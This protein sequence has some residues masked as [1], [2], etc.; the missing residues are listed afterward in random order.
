MSQE[1]TEIVRRLYEVWNRSGGVPALELIDPE[2]EVEAVDDTD[3][4]GAYRGHAGF[5]KLLEA[6]W[7]NFEDH[8]TEV[9][10]C[11]PRGDDVFVAVHYYGRGKGSGA[12]VDA[13]GWQVWTLRDGKAVRW[14]IFSTRNE[15]LEAAGL[16][17]QDAH[18]DS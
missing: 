18:A 9:E 4:G 1:N 11:L 5:S 16:S 12:E 6:T 14:R 2:I 10:E 3:L 17:E 13:R 15:A 7:G 8:R